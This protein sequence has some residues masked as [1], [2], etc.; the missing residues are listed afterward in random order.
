MKNPEGGTMAGSAEQARREILYDSQWVTWERVPAGPGDLWIQQFKFF[1]RWLFLV[2]DAAGRNYR[3]VTGD[4]DCYRIIEEAF[5]VTQIV[6][7]RNNGAIEIRE[8]GTR[9]TF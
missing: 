9:I 4:E 2:T 8:A 1:D 3:E 5:P 7:D 6:G